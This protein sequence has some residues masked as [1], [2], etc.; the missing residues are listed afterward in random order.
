M[1]YFFVSFDPLA[2]DHFVK[3]FS[4]IGLALEIKD[5]TQLE[6]VLGQ[7][8]GDGVVFIDLEKESS[9][10][11]DWAMF[12][13]VKAPQLKLIYIVS[14]MNAQELKAHQISPVGGDAYI[15]VVFE[16]ELLANILEG[17]PKTDM[18]HSGNR[19]EEATLSSKEGLDFEGLENLKEN[20]LSEEIDQIFR[21]V[22]KSTDKKPMLQ[23]TETFTASSIILDELGE[24]MSDKDQELSLDDLGDLELSDEN[25]VQETD[26]SDDGLEL[27]YEEGESLDLSD[28]DEV[29]IDSD[30]SGMDLSLDA[31]E[32]IS[33]SFDDAE[34][35]VSSEAEEL[36]LDD[37]GGHELSLDGDDLSLDAELPELSDD[38]LSLDEEGLSLDLSADDSLDLGGGTDFSDDAKEK[39]KE[40]DALMDMDASQVIAAESY[41]LSLDDNLSSL[42]EPLVSDDLNLDNLNFSSEEEEEPVVAAPVREEKSKRKK[43]EEKEEGDFGQDFKEI[44]GAYSGEMER[45]QATISNLRADREE[46]LAKL[47]KFE[48]EKTLQSRSTLSLRAELD[49]KKIELSI[50]RKKLNDEINDLKDRL[51][52]FD[53]KKL[54]L[55][56][57]NKALT[58]ELDR[59][60][61]KNKIDLKKVQLRERELEQRLELL[62]SD[63]ETQIRNRDLKI[64]ELKRRVDAMEFDMESITQQEKRSVESRFE[65]EDKLDKAIKTLRSAINVLENES[66]R[67]NALDALKKNLDV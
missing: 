12:I 61:Q 27:S 43:K 8:L 19:L 58:M 56:E 17:F 4:P 22:L 6:S 28:G 30:D 49:E 59:A 16:A 44:S 2:F 29:V 23:S 10:I 13:R 15:P 51:K 18:N 31:N 62:K 1:S 42:D 25:T 7:D 14:R 50:I 46:L 48:D 20:P 66:D 63:A 57:K 65:L 41:D 9:E 52:F 53:E 64:L 34:P 26:A 32:D 3:I 21:Q 60:S 37:D 40:I 39:L 5:K 55:E 47:Q 35:E 67:G 45:M 24:V 36:S 54:I 33:L 38:S 11:E